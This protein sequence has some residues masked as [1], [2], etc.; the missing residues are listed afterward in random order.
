MTGENAI[1]YAAESANNQ[2]VVEC[3]YTSNGG[4]SFQCS[5][6]GDTGSL[7]VRVKTALFQID[8]DI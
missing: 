2:N 6:D 4:G 3:T 5:Y 8:F 7:N 1:K